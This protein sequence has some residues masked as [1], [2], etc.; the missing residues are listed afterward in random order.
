MAEKWIAE[1][2]NP[3]YN[4]S[5]VL[6]NSKMA[7][8]ATAAAIATPTTGNKETRIPKKYRHPRPR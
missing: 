1:N 6:S 4:Y 8:Q 2:P 5:V 7:Q 3:I